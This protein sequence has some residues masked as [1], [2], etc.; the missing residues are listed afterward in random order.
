MKHVTT[1]RALI[2]VAV[3]ST[4]APDAIGGEQFIRLNVQPAS[5]PE[6]ALKYTLLPDI[7]E[8]NPGN[9]AQEYLK[10]F[11][12]QHYFFFSKQAVADRDRYQGVPLAELPLDK[13]RNYG[14][15]ALTRADWAARYVVRRR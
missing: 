10:C 5:A 13:V 6:P 7:T 4:T 14:G 3:L 8:L 9:A 1:A 15:G 12:E 11:M 2:V